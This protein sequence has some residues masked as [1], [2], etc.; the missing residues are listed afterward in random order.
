[1]ANIVLSGGSVLAIGGGAFQIG[2]S[3]SAPTITTAS[4]LPNA[5]ETSP[6]S[7]TIAATGGTTPYTWSITSQTGTN[8]WS[9]NSSTGV[10]TGTPGSAE[11][12][13]IVVKV[14]DAA[15][16]TNSKTFSLVVQSNTGLPSAVPSLQLINQGGPNNGP[17]NALE[18]IPGFINQPFNSLGSKNYAALS[19]LPATAGTNPITSYHIYRNNVLYDTITTPRQITGFIAPKTPSGATFG[20]GLLTV[21]GLS[22]GTTTIAN[23]D[24][25]C[26]AKL[27]SS[28]SGFNANTVINYYSDA[29][30]GGGGTGHYVVNFSQTAGSSGSPVTFNTW[31]YQDTVAT[32]CNDSSYITP[33]IVYAYQVAA[34]DSLGNEGPKT[35]PNVYL[36]QGISYTQ[37]IDFS[38]N[39]AAVYNST[40]VAPS[41]AGPY[42]VKAPYTTSGGDIPF[43]VFGGNSFGALC[44][45]Q[46]LEIGA[47]TGFTFDVMVTDNTFQ[48]VALEFISVLRAAG[49]NNSADTNHWSQVNLWSFGTAV[50]NQ[51]ATFRVPFSAI[52][53]GS[54]H[55]TASF[56][57]TAQFTGTLTVTSIQ[58]KTALGIDG[59]SWVIPPSGLGSSL[60]NSYIVGFNQNGGTGTY[61][62][63]GPNIVGTENISTSAGWTTN[64]TSAYKFGFQWNT[65]VNTTLYWDNFGLYT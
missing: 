32:N 11:T 44:P 16:L 57:G 29:D 36:F 22:G 34:V 40:A 9:I 56:V 24:L 54:V 17:T 65:N 35:V 23:G 49:F 59:S 55:F 21:T 64:G 48:T 25:L 18:T 30:T 47:F 5:T 2:S 27:F 63:F 15:T 39:A 20:A 26:G 12:D 42:V 46:R 14:T 58:S 52:G 28:A 53:Y 31:T 62:V 60:L 50:V 51:W 4:P 43:P 13:S 1:M 6:Y 45:S 41:S 38:T 8:T 33:G 61:T 10:L 3:A 19:W 7:T 37:A